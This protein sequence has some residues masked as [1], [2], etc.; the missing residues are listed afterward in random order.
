M[1]TGVFALVCFFISND[2]M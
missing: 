2:N 1:Y